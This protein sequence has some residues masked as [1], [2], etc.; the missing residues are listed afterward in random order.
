MKITLTGWVG[1]RLARLASTCV[2]AA[3]VLG[4]CGG[5]DNPAPATAPPTEAPSVTVS[6]RV[7]DGKPVAAA[8]VHLF[9]SGKAL[10][11][12]VTDVDGNYVFAIDA[13]TPLSAG[14]PLDA[15]VLGRDI[16]LVANNVVPADAGSGRAKA[17]KIVSN[18]SPLSTLFSALASQSGRPYIS[19][20]AEARTVAA[21]RLP[22]VAAS[23]STSDASDILDKLR[24]EVGIADPAFSPFGE[25]NRAQ[26]AKA[27]A[28]LNQGGGKMD[29][30]VFA[31]DGQDLEQWNLTVAHVAKQVVVSKSA[32]DFGLQ[33]AP[34]GLPE[35]AQNL[36]GLVNPAP[37][38][39][40]PVDTSYLE[41]LTAQ[42]D[43]CLAG[44]GAACAIAGSV[45]AAYLHDGLS[46]QQRLAGLPVGAR[47]REIATLKLLQPADLAVLGGGR[48][49]LVQFRI[50][51][52]GGTP[53]V[54]ND[55]VRLSDAGAPVLV[56]N[57]VRY[58]LAVSAFLGRGQV[59]IPGQGVRAVHEH[60]LDIG[61]PGSVP[62]PGGPV[63]IGSAKVEGSGLPAGGLYL[64]TTGS[65]PLT[66]PTIPATSPWIDCGSCARS[67]GLGT[68]FKWDRRTLDGTGV[69]ATSYDY[70]PFK[71]PAPFAVYRVTLFDW[72]GMQV[73]TPE[74]VVNF[75][76]TVSAANGH[77]VAW[78]TLAPDLVAQFLEPGGSLAGPQSTVTIQWHLPSGSEDRDYG[79][80]VATVG[81]TAWSAQAGFVQAYSTAGSPVAAVRGTSDYT[82]PVSRVNGVVRE[83]I[84][85]QTSREVRLSWGAGNHLRTATWAYRPQ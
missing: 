69:P 61:I 57:G 39:V 48:G 21:R 23:K 3:F 59:M 40:P 31:D 80:F 71:E 49:A 75:G 45:D 8:T 32:T 66:L 65:G 83:D 58:P 28:L 17:V 63:Q 19:P 24:D 4:G 9:L 46:F 53:S 38:P 6:G 16:P 2:A 35:A 67:D 52:A 26:F 7:L 30:P 20:A 85:A 60:G 10:G 77:S 5:D 1:G 54:W 36:I 76:A 13:G 33:V 68:Q 82:S 12:A 37:L 70:V 29:N 18:L 50:D 74:A 62:S 25:F 56:G 42:I 64:V 47:L 84:S 44:G 27:L 79:T 15:V 14:A 43:R 51:N 22:A 11:A 55:V 78:P 41:A 73:G 72:A 34:F 81:A